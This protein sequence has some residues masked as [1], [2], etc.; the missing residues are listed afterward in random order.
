[1]ID[2]VTEVGIRMKNTTTRAGPSCNDFNQRSFISKS[3]RDTLSTAQQQELSEKADKV[4]PS[5]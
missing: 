5:I 3:P 1:M 4:T 2:D